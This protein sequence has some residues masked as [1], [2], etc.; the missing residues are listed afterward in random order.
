MNYNGQPTGYT[1]SPIEAIN[2]ASVHDNQDLFDQVQL[3]SSLSD[4]IATRA[5]RQIMGMSNCAI[6]GESKCRMAEEYP[7]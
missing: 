6:D 1:K 5:R 7:S 2:Y 3:K 4:S